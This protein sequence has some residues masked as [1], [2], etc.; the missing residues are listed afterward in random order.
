MP[1]ESLLEA[2]HLVRSWPLAAIRAEQ[3]LIAALGRKRLV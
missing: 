1:T 3:A 2:I